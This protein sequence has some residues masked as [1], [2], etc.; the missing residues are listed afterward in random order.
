MTEKILYPKTHYFPRQPQIL[1]QMVLQFFLLT[2]KF[3][4]VFQAQPTSHA[5]I[6]PYGSYFDVGLLQA[7]GYRYWLRPLSVKK[8]CFL[9]LTE[10]PE[11][12]ELLSCNYDALHVFFG[13][14]QVDSTGYTKLKNISYDN[15]L[16]VEHAQPLICQLP[17]IRSYQQVTSI[18]PLIINTKN[19]HLSWKELRTNIYDTSGQTAYVVCSHA[20]DNAV[21]SLAD[22]YEQVTS[23]QLLSFG[24]E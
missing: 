21:E 1:H 2:D 15:D 20:M 9:I 8:I 4:H 24:Q 6:M 3:E 16:F 11:K 13:Q 18:M 22:A 10:L 19:P 17:F 12:V 5:M 7:A 14:L 23:E